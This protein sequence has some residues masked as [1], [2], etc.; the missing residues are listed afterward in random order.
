MTVPLLTEGS[1]SG[2]P[3]TNERGERLLGFHPARFGPMP[4][5]PAFAL[6]LA[7]RRS[8]ILLVRN[9]VRGVWEL[10]GGWI[11]PGEAAERCA[12]RELREE[13]G[14]RTR[15]A[16]L[17]GW[18]EI[19]SATSAGHRRSTGAVFAAQ[20]DGQSSFAANDEISAAAWWP[21]HA[22]PPETSAIDAW[23]I[24]HVA[25]G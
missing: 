20:A 19:E 3:V 7:R 1:S 14:C 16:S 11:E 25:G 4:D 5:A 6:V 17:L 15:A 22:P 21:V 24:A 10:P 12:L 2:L 13:S 9:A 8:R 23:L 18:I